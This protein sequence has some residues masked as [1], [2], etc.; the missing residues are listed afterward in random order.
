MGKGAKEMEHVQKNS[1]PYSEY[2]GVRTP[3]LEV[4]E[5]ARPAVLVGRGDAVLRGTPCVL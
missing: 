2:N 3:V 5:Y 4:L 1:R